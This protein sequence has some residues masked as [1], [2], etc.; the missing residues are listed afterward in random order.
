A[1]LGTEF[2]E[3]G[4]GINWPNQFVKPHQDKLKTCWSQPLDSKQSHAVKHAT[5]KAW[6]ALLEKVLVEEEIDEECIYA[7]DETSFQAGEG[8]KQQVI[9]R[10]GTYHQLQQHSGGRQQISWQLSQS[11]LIVLTSLWLSCMQV[12]YFCQHGIRKLP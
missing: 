3:E 9:E 6:F 5:K 1:R 12:V 7:M 11:V 4:L 2:P 8:K 10:A